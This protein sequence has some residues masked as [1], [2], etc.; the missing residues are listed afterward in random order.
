MATAAAESLSALYTVDETA[1]LEAMSTAAREGDWAALDLDH[2]SEYLSDMAI[3]DRREVKSRLVVFLTHLLKWSY[4]QEK[5]SR[6]WRTTLLHQRNELADLAGRGVLRAHAEAVLADT[7]DRAV[8]L[9]M[10]ETAL[11]RERLSA[12]VSVHGGAIV[13]DRIACGRCRTLNRSTASAAAMRAS[14]SALGPHHLSAQTPRSFPGT[15]RSTS[16]LPSCWTSDFHRLHRLHLHQ[17]PPQQRHP[18][19]HVGRQEPL[20]LARA[21]LADVD[22]RVD[23]AVGQLAVEHQLH[24]AGALE[25]LKDQRRPCGCRC[26]SGRCP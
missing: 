1:W 23:A 24:V 14:K 26:R 5:R 17:A 10:S 2:L 25:L 8:E 4:Q 12:I 13:L 16:V 6:S 11:S 7:Y 15:R 3:R 21:R 18:L 22:G 19:E 20:F 9:A